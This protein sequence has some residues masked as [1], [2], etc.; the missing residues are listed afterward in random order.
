MGKINYNKN[1]IHFIFYH[2]LSLRLNFC[3]LLIFSSKYSLLYSVL[4]G[5]K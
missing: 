5:L 3:S 4:L 1:Y 2:P